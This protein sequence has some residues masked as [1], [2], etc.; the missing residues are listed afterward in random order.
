[1]SSGESKNQISIQYQCQELGNLKKHL[2]PY[3]VLSNVCRKHAR[4]AE[5]VRVG[6]NIKTLEQPT[7]K[8]F[9][10]ST[11]HRMW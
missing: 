11:F 9:L 4:E 5:I 3:A 2:E 10:S 1:M 7:E 8:K 6:E